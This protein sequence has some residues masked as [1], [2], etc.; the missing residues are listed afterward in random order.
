[1]SAAADDPKTAAARVSAVAT[2]G[3]VAFL[4]GPP[5]LGFLGQHFGLLN[6]L[7][8]VLVLVTVAGVAS[9]SAREPRTAQ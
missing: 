9:G 7:L 8:V 5:L 3:Y 6:S 1:M 2:I 4:I